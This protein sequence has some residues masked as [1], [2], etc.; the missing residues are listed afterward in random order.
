M[1]EEVNHVLL[2]V[3]YLIYHTQSNHITNHKYNAFEILGNCDI[4]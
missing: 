4:R 1:F 2:F 3:I